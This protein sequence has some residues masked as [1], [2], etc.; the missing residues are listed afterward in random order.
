MLNGDQFDNKFTEANK[1]WF[2]IIVKKYFN[3]NLSDDSYEV[4]LVDFRYEDTT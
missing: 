2:K 1:D 3:G 4:F